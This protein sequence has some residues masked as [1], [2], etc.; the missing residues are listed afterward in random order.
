MA[1]ADRNMSIVPYLRP[2]SWLYG[3]V[4]GV[5]NAF[6]DSGILKS[7]KFDI[8]VIVVG[9]LSAGGTGKTP[10]TEYLISILRDDFQVAVLSRGYKR[11]TSGFRMVDVQSTHFEAGDEPL[12]MKKKYSDV[13]IAVDRDRVHGIQ[14]LLEQDPQ[15]EVVILDDAY[16]HRYVKPGL[17]ILLMDYNHPYYHDYYLPS[18]RLREHFNE[19][20]RAHLVV[21]TKCPPNLKPIERKLISNELRLYPYQK[22]YFSHIEYGALHPVFSSSASTLSGS[23]LKESKYHIL[24]VTGIA[25]PG[26]LKQY[27]GHLTPH[28]EELRFPDH[29]RYSLKDVYRI[30]KHFERIENPG[31][32]IITTEKDAIRLQKFH[33]IAH[34]TQDSWYCIPIKTG[35]GK[36]PGKDIRNQIVE[37]V[38]QNK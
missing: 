19:K 18:G 29:H 16:Q 30:L 13:T 8:P 26:P 20:K 15:P 11:K 27:L 38:E 17:S 10:F 25:D 21:V 14:I 32:V 6:F 33:N 37:Y 28:V 5:R 23:D 31:K 1:Q 24:L 34:Q 4:V 9:N 7:R 36:K 22:L 2:L 3:L 12:Q 35:F